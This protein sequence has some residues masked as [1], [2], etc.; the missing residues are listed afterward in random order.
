[1][2]LPSAL[3]PSP[4]TDWFF[5]QPYSR[6]LVAIG[7]S[8]SRTAEQLHKSALQ[9]NPCTDWFFHQPYSRSS[10]TSWFF[11]Q[12]YSRARAPIG[13]SISPTAVPL[14]RLVFPSALQPS[15]VP[16]GFSISP[17]AV[18]LHRLVLPSALQPSP[19]TNWFFHQPYSRPPCTNWFFHQP[20]SRATA[21]ISLTS[22]PMHRLVL[23]SALRSAIGPASFIVTAS[24]LQPVHTGN[25]LIKFSDD[26]YV[27]VPADNSD[28]STSS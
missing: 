4:C 14:H 15:P 10:C 2:V 23:P 1:L 13:S 24:D 27:I 28:T 20:Y 12:P 21:Q 17:T 3:Q 11:H 22:E 16:I 7:S 18:P 19:C 5:H 9:P 6:A 26:T 25:G 8:I